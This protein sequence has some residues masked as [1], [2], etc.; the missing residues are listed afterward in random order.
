MRGLLHRAEGIE[1]LHTVGADLP[2]ESDAE[3]EP[4][5]GSDGD[6]RGE[7]AGCSVDGLA[8]VFA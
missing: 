3:P 2:C 6:V 4:D 5:E 7:F 8:V 1:E